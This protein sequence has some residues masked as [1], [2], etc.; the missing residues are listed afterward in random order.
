MRRLNRVYSVGASAKE[1]QRH[2]EE[3]GEGRE[4]DGAQ[5]PVQLIN[6]S[7]KCTGAIAA[8]LRIVGTEAA[9]P[10][11]STVQPVIAATI[12]GSEVAII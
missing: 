10:D 6:N 2:S 7:G 9:P 5:N 1:P 8:D 3:R 12:S 11:L 4:E